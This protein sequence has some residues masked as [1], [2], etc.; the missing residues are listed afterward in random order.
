MPPL[1]TR[2]LFSNVNFERMTTREGLPTLTTVALNS[3]Y[4]RDFS[5]LCRGRVRDFLPLQTT[6][7][8]GPPLMDTLGLQKGYRLP[9]I[10]NALLTLLVQGIN[11]MYKVQ[12]L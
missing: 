10:V 4:L 2:V 11:G 9:T 8:C 3:Q 1:K 5:Q 6:Q 7:D 12:P